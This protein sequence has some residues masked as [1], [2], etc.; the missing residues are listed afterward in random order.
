MSQIFRAAHFIERNFERGIASLFISIIAVSLVINVFYRYVLASPLTWPVE[1]VSFLF[2]WFVYLGASYGVR[3]GAHIRLT[4]HI[5]LMPKRLQFI[6]RVIADLCWLFYSVVMTIQGISLV[7]S[8]FAFR[9][10]SQVLPIS[11]A[12]IYM[13]I[14]FAFCLMSLRIL[15]NIVQLVFGRIEPY[16][17]RQQKQLID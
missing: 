5:V 1:I 16:T 2:P 15:T 6:V 13:I 3:E 12:Y 9:Y 10:M 17:I 11:K 7:K 8:M 14:P 4:H